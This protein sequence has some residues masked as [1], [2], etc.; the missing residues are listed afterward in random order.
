M[1]NSARPGLKMVLT[2]VILT[3]FTW[4]SSHT[5]AQDVQ[6]SGRQLQV[7]GSRYVIKGVCYHPVPKNHDARNFSTLT[8]DLSLM[9]EA[10]VN[11][12]R[13][14]APIDD[15]DVLDEIAANGIKVIMG[16]GYN[17]DGN[18]DILSG[19]YLDY[20][21]KYKDHGAILLWE[22]GNEYNYHPEWFDGDLKN[23]YASLNE[24]AKAIH[25]EDPPVQ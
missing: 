9:L 11:T 18:Y 23:W 14:Y 16:F 19:S 20:I 3:C 22:L 25:V 24:A 8:Q 2:L 1:D 17:Q 12:I 10:G 7:D 13:V 21:R 5:Y 4:T 6:V 15:P